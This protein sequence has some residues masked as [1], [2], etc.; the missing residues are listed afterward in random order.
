MLV[1]SLLFTVIV[2]AQGIEVTE[3]LKNG[4]TAL[5][6]YEV[7]K[8]IRIYTDVLSKNA[9]N[10]EAKEKLGLI[11]S[12]PGVKQDLNNAVKYFAATLIL[13]I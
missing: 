12:A 1:L 4:V 7:D 3:L 6:N 10:T 11:Y 5:S 9:E 13:T 2:M 8:A